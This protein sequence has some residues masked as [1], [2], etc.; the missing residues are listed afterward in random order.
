MKLKL[1]S[2]EQTVSIG[3][4]IGEM[5]NSGDIICL[6]GDLGTGKT[7]LTKGIATGLSVE[8]HITSPLLI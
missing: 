6:I 7:H 1:N 4:Q 2:V 5:A 3:K 8:D